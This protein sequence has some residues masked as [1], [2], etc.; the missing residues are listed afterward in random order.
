MILFFGLKTCLFVFYSYIDLFHIIDSFFN[1]HFLLNLPMD[2]L[3]KLTVSQLKEKCKALNIDTAGLKKK[4]LVESIFS[5]E[6]SQSIQK[7]ETD[8]VNKTDSSSKPYSEM[9]KEEKYAARIKRFGLPQDK[10]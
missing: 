9:T 2:D 7:I 3:Y 8:L 6:N 5:H 1:L 10:K 4:E